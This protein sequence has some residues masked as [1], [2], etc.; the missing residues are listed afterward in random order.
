MVTDSCLKC[1]VEGNL[2]LP[3]EVVSCI[4][5]SVQGQIHQGLEHPW[6]KCPCPW[7]NEVTFKVH[8]N[9]NNSGILCTHVGG[10]GWQSCGCRV[11]CVRH[12]SLGVSKTLPKP[13]ENTCTH[14]SMLST[15]AMWYLHISPVEHFGEQKTLFLWYPGLGCFQLGWDF[16]WLS[17]IFIDWSQLSYPVLVTENPFIPSSFH[18]SW[19]CSPGING[20]SQTRHVV[21]IFHFHFLSGFLVIP[22]P[23]VRAPAHQISH[24]AWLCSDCSAQAFS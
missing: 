9:P 10:M 20:R 15:W 24:T 6:W 22:L 4:P 5:E 7:Q 18:P 23:A 14:S 19:G 11:S 3:R 16:V 8:P 2:L 13:A 21:Q 12:E 17:L 1:F